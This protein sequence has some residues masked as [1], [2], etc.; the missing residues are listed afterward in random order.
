M[1]LGA[2]DPADRSQ[3]LHL[4]LLPGNA[5]TPRWD[6]NWPRREELDG[7]PAGVLVSFVDFANHPAGQDLRRRAGRPPGPRRRLEEGQ[8]IY[9]S[10]R[11][12]REEKPIQAAKSR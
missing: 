7:L 6:G 1:Y 5:Q 8:Q 12:G 9:R 3:V 10:W 11:T 4:E 2:H